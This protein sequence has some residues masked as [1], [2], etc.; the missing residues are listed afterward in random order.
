MSIFCGLPTECTAAP[1][2]PS[3][4]NGLKRKIEV[5]YDRPFLG[6]IYG[7]KSE[8]LARDESL[9]SLVPDY[10]QSFFVENV[11]TDTDSVIGET[12]QQWLERTTITNVTQ[13]LLRRA[14]IQ[15]GIT[16][17]KTS[18]DANISTLD[19]QIENGKISDDSLAAIEALYLKAKAALA[20][21]GKTT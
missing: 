21:K 1:V 4:Q 5:K 3:E 12:Y 11:K 8:N 2:E 9:V 15:A 16:A 14:A 7:K 17:E 10:L 20:E 6:R 13:V 18:I 19:N